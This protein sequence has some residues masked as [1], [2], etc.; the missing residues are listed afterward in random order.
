MLEVVLDKQ[1]LVILIG[2]AAVLGVLSKCVAGFSLKRLVRAAGNMNKSSHALVRLIKAKFEHTCMISDRVQNVDAF[3]GKYLYEYRVVGLRLHTWRRMEKAAVWLCLI[4][5]LAGA[6]AWYS[7][8]GMGDQVLQY[9]AGG[10]GT[11][12]LVFLFQ[13]TGDEKYQLD[14]VKNYMVDYL[15]N[16]CARR[17]EKAQQKEIREEWKE[18]APPEPERTPI[19]SGV[20]SQTAADTRAAGDV[21]LEEDEP[22]P[23]PLASGEAGAQTVS[24]AAGAWEAANRMEP[25]VAAVKKNRRAEK[26]EENAAFS[27]RT[28]NSSVKKCLSKKEG[29][30]S[31]RSERRV[32]RPERKRSAQRSTDK[33]DPGRVSGLISMLDFHTLFPLL[34]IQ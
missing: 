17:Y 26:R 18:M 16:I 22:S 30:G 33:R 31:E 28:R 25:E 24:E 23:E 4:F 2:I 14:A 12:I 34:F 1:I 15:E 19:Q 8:Y 7:L 10:A 21:L 27:Q 11:A 9:A 32:Q 3:V 13:L 6:A 29:R 5:G 20:V